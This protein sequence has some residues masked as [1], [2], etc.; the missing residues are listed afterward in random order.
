MDLLVAP[1][2]PDVGMGKRVEYKVHE[3][4]YGDG[5]ETRLSVI[6]NK[7]QK[8]NI[9][10][11]M[12]TSQQADDLEEF[13]DAKAGAEPFL[14]GAPNWGQPLPWKCKTWDRTH[15]GLWETVSA[16]FERVFDVSSLS[17]GGESGPT[18]ITVLRQTAAQWTSS[19]PLLDDG[20]F[21]IETDTDLYKIGD[22]VSVWSAL[23][24]MRAPL[25]GNQAVAHIEQRTAA[26][27]RA[28]DPIMTDQTI[29][30]EIDTRRAK[31]GDG[32]TR[33]VNLPYLVT[34]G[35]SPVTGY[36]S[37]SGGS[38]AART[39]EFVLDGGQAPIRGEVTLEVDA[40]STAGR[41]LL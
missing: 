33:W 21:A 1:K 32:S 38:S 37:L 41:T 2:A 6:N 3:A 30:Y 29:G 20:T 17:G 16:T 15:E 18:G 36:G 34:D 27:W 14:Y 13:F 8:V 35:D 24:Y 28:F 26:A 25:P 4:S 5:Y 19:N 23:S 11:T 7:G 31:I 12:L 40:G 39:P 10:W 22:G 9:S